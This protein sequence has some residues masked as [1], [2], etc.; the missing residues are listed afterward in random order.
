VVASRPGKKAQQQ[1]SSPEPFEF[2]SS[3]WKQAFRSDSPVRDAK[4]LESTQSTS[5][6]SASPSISETLQSSAMAAASSVNGDSAPIQFASIAGDSVSLVLTD[7]TL[8]ILPAPATQPGSADPSARP[9]LDLQHH[10][11]F[12]LA[13]I[14]ALVL[15]HHVGET[16]G[17]DQTAAGNE[18]REE[19]AAA[20]RIDDLGVVLSDGT[21]FWCAIHFIFFNAMVTCCRFIFIR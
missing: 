12:A 19:I 13:S 3:I 9:V 8:C 20:L 11:A 18:E 10:R 14:A 15:P 6:A 7:S 21:W 2:F 5:S 17:G 16:A 1:K 4:P